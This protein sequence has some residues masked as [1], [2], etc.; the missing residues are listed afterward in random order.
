[1]VIEIRST[2]LS[3]MIEHA[4]QDAPL[5]CC[6]LL[7]GVPGLIEE[8]VRTRN[9]RESERTYLIDPAEHLAVM[10]RV[11]GEG[12]AVLGAYHSHPRSPAVPSATDLAEA[13][14]EEFLYVIVSLADQA[15]PD[16][17]GYRLSGRN[18]LPVPL[19]RVGHLQ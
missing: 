4:R 12:R 6:G 11:R 17:R 2:V 3:A 19:V 9:V 10:K 18:F 16:V 14:Y 15:A 5:E 8:S 1:L 13:H 7:V